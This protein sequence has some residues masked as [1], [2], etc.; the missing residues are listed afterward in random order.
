[1]DKN[2]SQ[3][4]NVFTAI[5]ADVIK[6]NFTDD[7]LTYIF[8]VIRTVD[9]R[10]NI[11]TWQIS[12]T[13]QDIEKGTPVKFTKKI[14][15]RGMEDFNKNL[16]GVVHVDN[17]THTGKSRKND[18]TII[19]AGKNIGKKNET[20]P[21]T[22][23]ILHASSKYEDKNRKNNTNIILPMLLK[24]KKDVKIS[25]EEYDGGLIAER[26]YDGIRALSTIVNS[27]IEIYSRTGVNYLGLTE[28]ENELKILL[29]TN[30]GIYIDGEL[31]RHGFKLQDISGAVRGVGRLD[32]KMLKLVI[33]DCYLP[34][35]PNLSALERK[36][37]L[38]ELFENHIFSFIEKAPWIMV[39]TDKEINDLLQTYLD[40][41]FEG[42]ILRRRNLPYE[43]SPNNY[44]SSNVLK[45][46]P[47][48]T[49]EFLITG[50]SEGTHGKDVGALI[51]NCDGFSAVP[52]GLTYVER[53]H[54]F[55]RFSDNHMTLYNTTAEKNDDI[56]IFDKYVN[57]KNATIQ[58][59][60][61]SK[62]GKPQQPKFINIRDDDIDVISLLLKE[63]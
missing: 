21:V 1:M 56:S 41:D 24:D 37:I 19:R 58:Y 47:F 52:K 8:P 28:I 9:R 50:F 61:L 62:D 45:V 25:Q 10:S 31:Y 32:R 42:V 53:Y 16:V 7:Q 33:F 34:E 20:N 54:I 11:S 12:V 3:I 5:Q 14:L 23:A 39:S 13:I 26:K 55:K 48:Q 57:G 59:S 4:S 17:I 43:Q 60:I 35:K 49:A 46:K 15:T 63:L 51:I 36:I 40:D 6:G 29:S 27:N 44:H 18:D 38:E 30:T 22:Q 2:N